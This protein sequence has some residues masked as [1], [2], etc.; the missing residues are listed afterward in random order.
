MRGLRVGVDAIKPG[1]TVG[2]IARE[3]DRKVMEFGCK[4]MH[5]C[6]H[7]MGLDVAE[8]PGITPDNELV[9]APGMML[10]VHPLIS[11][12]DGSA[13]TFVGDTY[14]VDGTGPR[15]L[16]RWPCSLDIA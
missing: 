11:W 10:T 12:Q 9:L 16:S 6:G 2:A 7:G 3:I 4:T 15:N 5:W 13:G 1:N 14:V 8:A